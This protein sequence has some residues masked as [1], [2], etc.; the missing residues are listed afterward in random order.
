MSVD[1]SLYTCM[2]SQRVTYTQLYDEP[3]MVDLYEIQ[4]G[5]FARLVDKFL[6]C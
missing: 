2:F 3:K 1:C 5:S 4:Q 6:A